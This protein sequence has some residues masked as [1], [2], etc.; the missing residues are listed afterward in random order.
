MELT[1]RSSSNP[2]WARTFGL[3]VLWLLA[4]VPV[5]GQSYSYRDK[6]FGKNFIFSPRGDQI[7]VKFLPGTRTSMV[8]DVRDKH[9]LTQRERAQWPSA[10]Y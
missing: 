10:N 3:F 6:H 9:T 5:E 7:A 4:A 8:S 2:L 1:R